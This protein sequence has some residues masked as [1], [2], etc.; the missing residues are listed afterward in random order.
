MI[1]LNLNRDRMTRAIEDDRDVSFDDFERS[2]TRLV[3]DLEVVLRRTR[4]ASIVIPSE[5][6][7]HAVDTLMPPERMGVMAGRVVRGTNLLGTPYDVTGRGHQAH[8]SADPA[9]LG[10]AL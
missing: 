3:A 10:R 5:L 4:T 8:V 1:S 6:L 7:F 2:A 9:K